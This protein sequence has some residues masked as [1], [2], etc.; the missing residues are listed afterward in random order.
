V[1]LPVIAFAFPLQNY[2]SQV[3]AKNQSRCKVISKLWRNSD[4]L[5]GSVIFRT[6]FKQLGIILVEKGCTASNRTSLHIRVATSHARI[7]SRTEGE[8]G[9]KRSVTDLITIDVHSSTIRK[10]EMSERKIARSIY[11][12]YCARSYVWKINAN[13]WKKASINVTFLS[14]G[15]VN[16]LHLLKARL[17]FARFTGVTRLL[18]N[19]IR[20]SLQRQT[21]DISKLRV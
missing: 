11:I 15:S 3:H 5:L 1:L 17:S 19:R 20:Q 6:S 7:G 8:K 4:Y 16:R 12:E 14:S 13:D 18:R 9:S 2:L 10:N 21:T